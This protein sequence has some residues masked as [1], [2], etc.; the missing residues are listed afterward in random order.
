MTVRS[1]M[2]DDFFQ[3]YYVPGRAMEK[4]AR[5]LRSTLRRLSDL[6]SASQY[7]V[8]L[9]HKEAFPFGPPWIEA[10]LRRRARH[11]IYDMDDAYWT[12]PP[13]LKQIAHRFRDPNRIPK[14]LSLADHVLAGNEF[15]ASYARQYNARVTVFPTVLDMERFCPQPKRKTDRVTVGWVGHWA[16]T[17]YL[18]SRETVFSR[19]LANHSNVDLL[20][21]GA[22]EVATSGMPATTV[23]WRL[24]QEIETISGFDI[25]IMPLPD[26]TYAQGKCGLKL[27]QYMALGIPAV[28]SPIGVNKT[29]I[30]DGV[31]GFL[32]QS[33][34]EW[35][36]RLTG[37]ILDP[38]LRRT[39]GEAGRRTVEERFS[40]KRTAPILL[41]IMNSL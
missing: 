13:Q 5:T 35:F 25:G 26:D 1:F 36:D 30:Q 33:E 6:G 10:I 28:A 9:I 37:L 31:N 24:D 12:H 38:K 15:L 17:P 19:L 40:V 39:I 32:A 14:T 27:L 34:D 7:D 11:V 23:P 8:V 41:E 21:V 2:D 4:L 20:L 29:I 18:K 16:S 3:M 22:D